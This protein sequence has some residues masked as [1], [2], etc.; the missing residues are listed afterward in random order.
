MGCLGIFP[1]SGVSATAGRWVNRDLD[2]PVHGEDV[3]D[4]SA[5]GQPDVEVRGVQFES[6]VEPV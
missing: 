6:V 5:F 2:L 1:C 4:L 3:L